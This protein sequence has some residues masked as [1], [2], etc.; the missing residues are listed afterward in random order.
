MAIR[1]SNV[2]AAPFQLLPHHTEEGSIWHDSEWQSFLGSLQSHYRATFQSHWFTAVD[3]QINRI[4][5]FTCLDFDYRIL[6]DDDRSIREH[7]RTN[8]GDHEN[9]RLRCQDWAARRKRIG[10]G[11]GWCRDDQPVRIEFR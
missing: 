10:G 7:M 3:S 8:R 5:W 6:P 11:A 2:T 9:S 1:S 4:I